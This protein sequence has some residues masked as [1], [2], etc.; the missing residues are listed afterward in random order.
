MSSL[1][2][3]YDKEMQNIIEPYLHLSDKLSILLHSCC[4]PCSSSVIKRLAPFFKITVFYYNPNID[5]FD[6]Y[7]KRAEEQKCLIEIYNQKNISMFP[8]KIIEKDYCKSDFEAVSSG[9]EHIPEGG[10]RCEK[11]YFL[12][13]E[14]T[15]NEA[16]N[17]GFEF[18]CTTL[19]VSPLKNAE[20]INSIGFSLS[21]DKC[22]WLPSDFKKRNGYLDSINLSKQLGLYRQDYCGCIYSK[23]NRI[24]KQVIQVDTLYKET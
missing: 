7:K 22:R 14:K 6:E 2:K 1:K 17:L 21:E 11:C 16:K 13:M 5:T 8:I 4:A 9:L 19:S 10:T 15:F 23:N 3:N 24:K 12:R 20:K 18:F